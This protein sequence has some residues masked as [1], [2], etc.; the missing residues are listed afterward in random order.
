MIQYFFLEVSEDLPQRVKPSLQQ[1]EVETRKNL[2]ELR[3]EHL[4]EDQF[5]LSAN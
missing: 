4:T 2:L 1:A 5:T 3:I